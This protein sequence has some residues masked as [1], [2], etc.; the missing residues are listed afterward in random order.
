MGGRDS[1][2]PAN[3]PVVVKFYASILKN[4]QEKNAILA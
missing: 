3:K 4:Q 2:S 1:S